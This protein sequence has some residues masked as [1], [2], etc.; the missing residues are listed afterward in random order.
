MKWKSLLLICVTT[1]F[2]ISTAAVNVKG[3]P[4]L[5]SVFVDP[6]RIV[7]K[8]LVSGQKFTV[9]IKIADVTDLWGFGVNIKWKSSLLDVADNPST[10]GIVEGVTEG[11][12]LKTGGET[13]FTAKLDQNQGT[14]SVASTLLSGGTHQSGDGTLFTI[15]FTVQELGGTTLDLYDTGVNVK[16]PPPDYTPT[17]T[18]HTDKDGFFANTTVLVGDING[19]GKVD[20]FDVVLL[21]KAFGTK[22]GD[23]AWNQGA[24]LNNDG[25]VDIFDVVTIAKNF[26]QSV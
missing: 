21:A 12:F 25:I 13:K 11:N 17:P 8:T 16:G 6:S 19:D 1:V 24:D 9:T 26:G 20:I 4:E 14:L 5:P 22:P 18:Q 2:L 15:E 3:S 7:D 23:P 10:Q